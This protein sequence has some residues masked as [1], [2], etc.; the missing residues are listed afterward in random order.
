MIFG[1]IIRIALRA[2]TINK[3]R[4]L[5]TMLGIIIGI[6]TA[7]VLISAGQAVEQYI[8]NLFAGIGTNVLFVTPGQ[9]GENQD[10]TGQPRYGELT[11]GDARALSNP[12]LVP[13]MVS[14]APE[15]TA[16]ATLVRGDDSLE[17]DLV[18]ISPQHRDIVGWDTQIGEFVSHFDMDSRRRVAIL[19]HTA[20]QDLY[21]PNEN[22]LGTQIRVNGVV[23]TV[24]GVMKEIGMGQYGNRDNS[25]FLPYTTA[26]ERIL[27]W[28][29]TRGDYKVSQ[30]LVS[31]SA[32]ERMQQAQIDIEEALRERH[33]IDYFEED[34]FSVISQSDFISVFGDITAVVTVFLGAISF[35]SLLVGGIG[36]M[37]IMLVSV[38]ERTREIGLR[39]AIG[40]RRRDILQQFLAEAVFLSV[41]GGLFGML[42]G[43]GVMRA[44]DSQVVALQL[45]LRA[46]TVGGVVAFC[47]VTG[48][49]F[50]FW[51]AV[52]AS[53]LSPINAL[54]SD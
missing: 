24:N 31:V 17:V 43:A 27:D 40:A 6:S 23:F 36:I 51:P 2:L 50:G 20:F 44:A 39:K 49:L 26:M 45:T 14:V 8:Y 35:V 52:Q 47:M 46:S 12:M 28:K 16:R 19:G 34:D 18:A 13:D 53:R 48:I 29:T 9:L 4:S 54:R 21:N 11:L 25:V 10:P 22:P 42:L 30:I 32:P 1:E 15:A 38:A 33:R 5:L 3:L 41:L 7:T 37:N